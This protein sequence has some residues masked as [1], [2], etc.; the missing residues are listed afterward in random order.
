ML[1]LI[2]TANTA[3][4]AGTN[5]PANVD[6]N[7]NPSILDY[8]AGTNEII[9]KAPGIYKITAN[10]VFV[11]T[12]IGL[13]TIFAFSST[14]NAN[15]PGMLSAFESTVANQDATYTIHKNVAISAQSLQ[16]FARM[17]LRSATVGN[18]TNLVATVEKIR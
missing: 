15:V 3:I 10:V 1:Q 8:N 14:A 4:T 7:T 17:S 13:N 11:P 2:N 12:A 9:F 5:I 6:F 18:M 16:Q